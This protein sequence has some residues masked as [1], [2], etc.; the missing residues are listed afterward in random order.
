MKSS[1]HIHVDGPEFDASGFLAEVSEQVRGK[2]HSRKRNRYKGEGAAEEYWVSENLP[3]ELGAFP[4]ER[5]YVINSCRAVG[6]AAR[7]HGGAYVA[8]NVVFAYEPG[9]V[10]VGVFIPQDVIAELAAINA[11]VD[12]DY[13]PQIGVDE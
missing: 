13:V 5:A 7:K 6:N 11:S 10:P 1:S 4:D 12:V 2:A 9:E 3:M 8:L